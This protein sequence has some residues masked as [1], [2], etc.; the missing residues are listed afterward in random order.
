MFFKNEGSLN[1]QLYD[2]NT[3]SIFSEPTEFPRR[4]FCSLPGEQPTTTLWDCAAAGQISSSEKNK[5]CSNITGIDPK[6][7][8]CEMEFHVRKVKPVACGL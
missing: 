2:T 1:F 6:V 4:K 5:F 3:Q 7:T 8:V